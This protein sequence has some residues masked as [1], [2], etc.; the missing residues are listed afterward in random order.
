MRR[1][2]R[3]KQNDLQLVRCSALSPT[4]SQ[5]RIADEAKG[6]DVEEVNEKRPKRKAKKTRLV[7]GTLLCIVNNFQSTLHCR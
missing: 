3:G 4:F 7:I 5:P 1:D 6:E 2:L